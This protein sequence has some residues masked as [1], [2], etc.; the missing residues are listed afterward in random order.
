VCYVV[1]FRILA[2]KQDESAWADS[3]FIPDDW[4]Y[5]AFRGAIL[6]ILHHN[7]N[8]KHKS[9]KIHTV[10]CPDF[11]AVSS[12][13]HV[14]YTANCKNVVRFDK[15]NLLCFFFSTNKAKFLT[16]LCKNVFFE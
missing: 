13:F 16:H 12:H 14:R 11:F 3:S 2:T 4:A 15:K 7:L 8:A 6:A 10:V 1:L 9:D 5:T